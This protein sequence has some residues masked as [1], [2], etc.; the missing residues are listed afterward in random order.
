M[1]RDGNAYLQGISDGSRTQHQEGLS[2]ATLRS[3]HAA[4]SPGAGSE[5]LQ[6]SMLNHLEKL[7]GELNNRDMQTL[8]L[9]AW[10]K[11]TVTQASMRAVY[12]PCNPFADQN[13]EDAF[14]QVTGAPLLLNFAPNI[15]AKTAVKARAIVEK[16]FIRYYEEG[17]LNQASALAKAR[18]PAH[19]NIYSTVCMV[20]EDTVID[21]DYLLKKDSI[22]LI[23]NN[24]IHA[25]HAVWDP[26]A[27]ETDFYRFM[28]G[29]GSNA[30]QARHTYRSFG[31]APNL[32]PGRHFATTEILAI[33]AI[34]LIRYDIR[35][36]S[37]AWKLP[38]N[39]LAVFAA[40]S[41]PKSDLKVELKPRE[42]W[43]GKWV[44]DIGNPTVKPALVC[45]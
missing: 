13:V 20:L 45:G 22:L 9:Y 29:K 34:M 40:I 27:S 11:H 43:Q 38:E 25:S 39:E 28:P 19:E 15:L 1:L 37:G 42:G 8:D 26:T 10:V 24:V 32:C 16:A 6:I 36:V 14:W 17:G 4:F 5:D 44:F 33:L 21:G 2:S 23:P 41:P 3:F 31:G 18:G 35:P 12:G 7:L 30:K